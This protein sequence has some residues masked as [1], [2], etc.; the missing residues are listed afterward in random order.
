MKLEGL[1]RI[2]D[3]LVWV[4]LSFLGASLVGA[5]DIT[6]IWLEAQSD[7]NDSARGAPL[8]LML[9]NPAV[10]MVAAPIVYFSAGIAFVLIYY[11]LRDTVRWMSMACMYVFAITEVVIVGLK[12]DPLL[13]ARP[14]TPLLVSLLWSQRPDLG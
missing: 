4:W 14:E 11:W 5:I 7:P 9:I 13:E 6:L 8:L 3:V 2:P 10:L 12:Y 1:E